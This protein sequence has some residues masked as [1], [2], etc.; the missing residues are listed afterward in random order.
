MLRS[1]LL[2]ALCL[3]SSSA[4][5]TDEA[6]TADAASP[7]NSHNGLGGVVESTELLLTSS[8][9]TLLPQ[10]D[11]DES[12]ACLDGS[13]YGFYFT[14]SK[15]GSTQ[16]TISIEGGGW[17]YDEQ[18]C[19]AERGEESGRTRALRQIPPRRHTTAAVHTL[20]NITHSHTHLEPCPLA[21]LAP[22][23]PRPLAHLPTC[24]TRPFPTRSF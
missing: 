5:D 18:R 6:L 14:P 4:C 21:S 7:F 19:G 11:G 17:C 24:P 9:L 3:A 13:P 22:S 1:V 15:T 16:W 10:V 12:P 23:P 20:R 2:L 8:P